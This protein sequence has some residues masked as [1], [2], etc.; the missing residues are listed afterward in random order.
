MNSLPD[1]IQVHLTNQTISCSF[2]YPSVYSNVESNHAK[3]ISFRH[4]R[5]LPLAVKNI[6]YDDIILN[7]TDFSNISNIAVQ[8]LILDNAWL[9]NYLK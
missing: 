8:N 2:H 9:T 4:L 1:W 3:L 5:K 6:K 7:N